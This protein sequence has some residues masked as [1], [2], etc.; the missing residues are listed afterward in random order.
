MSDSVKE[1]R[2]GFRGSYNG[3]SVLVTQLE[4]G[5]KVE[6]RTRNRSVLV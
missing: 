2:R 6:R 1:E 5:E 3:D 4:A